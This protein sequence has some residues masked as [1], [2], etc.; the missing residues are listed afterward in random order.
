MLELPAGTGW[1]PRAA[2]ENFLAR[3]TFAHVDGVIALSHGV[4]RHL[5]QYIPRLVGKV[6]VIYNVGVP[7][8]SQVT[9]PEP[10]GVPPKKHAIRY[11]ACGRLA[12]Q[13]GYPYLLEAFAL[14][15]RHVDAEL[16][17]LGEG[18]QR[19]E[20]EALAARLRIAERVTFLGFRKNPFL[21][22]QAADVFVLSSLWEGFANVIVEAMSMGT[23]V[24]AADC[25]YGPNEI[26]TDGRN[27]LLVP[28]ANAARLG[29][30]MISLAQDATLRRAIA[31]A[32]QRRSVDFSART[33]A[34][35]YAAAF[36]RLAA[37]AA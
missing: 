33:I 15:E 29:E 16:H 36:R 18:P 35:Q 14:V 4:G 3:R 9:S 22:M 5:E 8:V 28:P 37:R 6:E 10:E 13:K 11:L 17:V 1:H 2:I 20:L 19:A 25:P 32:G 23:A 21:H 34:S 24:I 26:I 7:H 12:A 27:G 30:A 31:E